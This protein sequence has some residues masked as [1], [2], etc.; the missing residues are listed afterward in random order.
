MFDLNSYLTR[1]QAEDMDFQQFLELCRNDKMAYASAAQR[2]LM[3]IGEPKV[4]DTSDDPRLSRIFSNRKV[5]MYDA[6]SDFYG[7]EPQIEQIVGFLRHAA[8]GL[9]ESKQILYLLGPVG[10]AKSSLAERLKNLMEK[11]PV[12]VLCHRGKHGIEMSPVFE[13]PLGLIPKELRE[14]VEREFDIPLTA[15]PYCLSPWALKRLGEDGVV[16][17][18]FVRKM[19]PSQVKQI[20]VSR[21]EPSDDNNQDISSLVGKIDIRQLERFSQ[22]DPDAYSYSG[23]LNKG[24]RGVVEMVEIFKAPIKTLHPL[25][26]A[27]QERFYHGTEAIGG[28]PFDGIVLAHSNES[29]WASFR[30]NSRNEAFLDRVYV[31]R[32]PYNL[33]VIEEEKI[34]QKII[35]NSELRDAP[36]APKTLNLLSRFAVFS[37][38]VLPENSTPEVKIQV[39]DG[40]AVKEKNPDAR[41]LHEY[42]EVA[43]PDEGMSG[44]STRFAFKVLSKVYNLPDGEVSA[45]PVHLLMVLE[46]TIKKESLP[47]EIEARYLGFINEVLRKEYLNFLTKELQMAYLDSYKEYGQNMFDRYIMLADMWLQNK[48]YRDPDTGLTM[49]R[50]QLNEEL[51]QIEKAAG[52]SNPRDFRA[53]VFGFVMRQRAAGR[54][55]L[56]TSYEKLREVIEAKMFSGIRDLLPVISFGTKTSADEEEKHRAFL[57]HMVANG[58]TRLQVRLLVENYIR[59]IRHH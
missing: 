11:Y 41:S 44:V 49:D 24:N 30:N 51:E 28:I 12:Y 4:V 55:V 53:D 19:Y 39:Y 56:W 57:D 37:R 2:L 1:H 16:D 59:S 35:R 22:D 17:N 3:S 58:Y 10:S 46:D 31:I 27:T 50:A 40:E 54:E 7:I 34:Y 45:N 52:I 14:N 25:L 5:K 13:N 6:F 8:Q 33:R 9:E 32:I 18:F 43:G 29:E 36:V 42:Q 20:C 26:A 47:G 21:T 48:D 15:Y 38:I 23:A